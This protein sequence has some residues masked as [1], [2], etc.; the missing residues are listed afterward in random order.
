MKRLQ[1]CDGCACGKDLPINCFLLDGECH[2]TDDERF[3]AS[4][5][6]SKSMPKTKWLNVD[7]ELEVESLDICETL[8]QLIG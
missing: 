4:R 2:Y 3:S 1:L 5:T 8:K 7:G 6:F